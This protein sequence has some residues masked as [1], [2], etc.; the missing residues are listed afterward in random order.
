MSMPNPYAAYLKQ[1]QM[2]NNINTNQQVARGVQP[3]VPPISPPVPTTKPQ[4]GVNN[5]VQPVSNSY[6][7][8]KVMTAPP[9]E[10]TLMLYQG[11]IKFMNQAIMFNNEDKMPES[12]QANQRAQAIIEELMCTLD[13]RQQISHQLFS[14]YQFILDNLIEG[15]INKDM[16]KIQI[17]I[18]LT[19]QLRETWQE[20]MKLAKKG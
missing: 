5:T 12:N 18:D 2:H 17:S 10:L 11:A 19:N 16:N 6:L 14:M 4:A 9:E 8:N 3:P 1:A 20:A 15:N 7:A 13:M